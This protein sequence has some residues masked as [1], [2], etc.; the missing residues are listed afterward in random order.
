MVILL[1]NRFPFVDTFTGPS[2]PIK[3][4]TQCARL[5]ENSVQSSLLFFRTSATSR[6]TPRFLNESRIL[7]PL[8]YLACVQVLKSAARLNQAVEVHFAPEEGDPYAVELAG[9]VGGYVTG[10]DSDFV[11]LNTDGYLGYIPMTEFLWS[12]SIPDSETASQVDDEDSEFQP[13]RRKKKGKPQSSVNHGILPPQGTSDLVLSCSTF[14]PAALASHLNLPVSLL[15]LLGALVGNDYSTS[16]RN[17]QSMFF[18]HKLTLSQRITRV[19]TTLRAVLTASSGPKRK[20]KQ[21]N[22]VMDLIRR[23][24][25]ALFIRDVSQMPSGEQDAII[26]K[27][28]ESTLQYAIRKRDDTVPHVSGPECLLHG[29]TGGESLIPILPGL[30]D[31]SNVIRDLYNNAYSK[32][33]LDPKIVDILHSGTCWPKVFLEN[34]D[35]ETVPKSI[36]RPIREWMYTILDD[37][38]GLP[39]KSEDPESSLPSELEDDSTD[40]D[41]LIDVTEYSSSS[42]SEDDLLADP[43]APL[44]GALE[45]LEGD[46]IPPSN[47]PTKSFRKAKFVNEYIRRGT[48]V[49]P[50][51]IKVPV[52][53][54]YLAHLRTQ[55][56]TPVQITPEPSRFKLLIQIMSSEAASTSINTLPHEQIIPVLAIRSVLKTLYHRSTRPPISKERLQEKWTKREVRAALSAFI[57]TP[58]EEAIPLPQPE[59]H[60]RHVQ[61]VAQLL[62][63]LESVI[64]LSQV[65]LFDEERLPLTLVTRLS[66]KRFHTLLNEGIAGANTPATDERISEELWT[67]VVAGLREDVFGEDRGKKARKER[68]EV[69]RREQAQAASDMIRTKSANGSMFGVL[70]DVDA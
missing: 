50:E 24:V 69:R 11:I 64:L 66:G 35:A 7:P 16:Y 25:F 39:E 57:A 43:L 4:D 17:S 37:G 42:D 19:S 27:I 23:T 8:S 40:E 9:K 60:D 47:T 70:D 51:E 30:P 63:A 13:V 34:P 12:S 61:L 1:L 65:L 18:D 21:V 29:T 58:T 52:L 20:Q 32:G 15:P 36:G 31:N 54:I 46:P 5:T 2:P 59:I 3:F 68:K 67:S 45:R 6:S 33:N 55:F 49:A 44:R 56:A 38:V 28:V 41:E 10:Y 48:R 22:S 53:S 62:A 14:S 26:D